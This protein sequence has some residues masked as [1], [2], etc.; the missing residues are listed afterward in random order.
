MK[1][2]IIALCR[3]SFLGKGD[4]RAFRPDAPPPDLEAVAAA[5]YAPQRLEERFWTLEHLLLPSL[6]GQSE[7]DFTLALATSTA[8]PAPWRDRLARLAAPHRWV[9]VVEAE[10]PDLGAALA[11][12][13]ADLRGPAPG[14]IQVRIDDDDALPADY[15]ARLAAFARRM[16]G[17]GP[18]AY[19]R[20][21]GLVL[22][23]YPGQGLRGFALTQA[24]HS[25]GTAVHLTD[26]D[27]TIFH[28]G[29]FALQT[30]FPSFLDSRGMGFLAL[31]FAGHDSLAFDATGRPPK[32]L[33]PLPEDQ[34]D[35]LL[36]QSF[37]GIDRTAL[38]DWLLARA[39][40]AISR[41]MTKSS[42]TPLPHST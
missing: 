25:I 33:K 11:P 41:G 2:P 14:T 24:F 19:S 37:P 21:R 23:A 31:K 16:E 30:R 20:G 1:S 26:P 29:H 42:T 32:G 5:L 10:T 12:V 40:Q 22:T 35:P 17:F 28:Y 39:G 9:R 38:R 15:I 18:F 7:P 36:V 13:L 4:W 27:Q 3:F 6:A 8:M 34:I